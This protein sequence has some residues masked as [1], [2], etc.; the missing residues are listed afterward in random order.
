MSKTPP[1]EYRVVLYDGEEGPARY[2]YPE[3]PT[4]DDVTTM[5][6]LLEHY[7]ESGY[8]TGGHVEQLVEFAGRDAEY[9]VCLRAEEVG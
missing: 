5:V 9:V 3:R 8:A 4:D 6:E 2:V 1:S 7:V